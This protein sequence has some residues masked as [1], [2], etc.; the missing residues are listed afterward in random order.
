MSQLPL[1]APVV[2]HIWLFQS[3]CYKDL[4][5]VGSAKISFIFLILPDVC[6][7]GAMEYHAWRLNLPEPC[8]KQAVMH[9]SRDSHTV[10]VVI[11]EG[12]QK[13][14]EHSG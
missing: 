12:V 13:L 8:W 4:A 14:N 11:T 10:Y 9:Y 2:I 3:H 1:A 6:L 7:T 5:S